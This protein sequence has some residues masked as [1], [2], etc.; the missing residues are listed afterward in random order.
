MPLTKQQKRWYWLLLLPL[1]NVFALPFYNRVDPTLFG[2]P[3]F[4]WYQ[5]AWVVVCSVVVAI[6][7]RMAHGPQSRPEQR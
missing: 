6:V 7:F 2:I 5:L 3:L 1:I 4:Y